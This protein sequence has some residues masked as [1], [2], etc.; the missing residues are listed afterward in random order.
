MKK[1]KN[2]WSILIGG[3]IHKN[4]IYITRIIIYHHYLFII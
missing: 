4:R 1:Q 3:D 2:S